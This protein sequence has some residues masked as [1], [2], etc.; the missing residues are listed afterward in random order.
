MTAGSWHHIVLVYDGS[1]DA[2]G[3]FTFY[4]NG[5][6]EAATET[7]SSGSWGDIQDTTSRF[8]I[9]A[10]VGANVANSP[11]TPFD[12]KISNTKIYS[13]LLTAT[14]VKQNYRNAKGRYGL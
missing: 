6:N 12:G 4:V 11:L 2:A 14:E 13:R 10:A 3:R 1:I 5:Q 9:G 7:Y 8:A